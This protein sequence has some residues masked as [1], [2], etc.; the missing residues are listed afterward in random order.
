MLWRSL[1]E[2]VSAAARETVAYTWYAPGVGVV[3]NERRG[4]R[5]GR[6]IG[7][8]FELVSYKVP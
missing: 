4:R 8:S 5:R 3:K 6:Q 2:A 7:G 1:H